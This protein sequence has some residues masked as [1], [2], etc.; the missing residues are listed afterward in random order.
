M[1]TELQTRITEPAANTK[2]SSKMSA[3]LTKKKSIF[4]AYIAKPSLHVPKVLRHFKITA[5][6]LARRLQINWQS[7]QIFLSEFDK[8]FWHFH[9]YNKGNTGIQINGVFLQIEAILH[10]LISWMSHDCTASTV[11][12]PSHLLSRILSMK[13]HEAYYTRVCRCCQVSPQKF[14]AWICL[15]Q[16]RDGAQNPWCAYRNF[17]LKGKDVGPIND[18]RIVYEGQLLNLESFGGLL[19]T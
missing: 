16:Q 13:I 6:S 11:F 3:R 5:E 8:R 1:S 15:W 4:D 19:R 18:T 14:E 10:C 12:E 9:K 17:K 7:W 2:H